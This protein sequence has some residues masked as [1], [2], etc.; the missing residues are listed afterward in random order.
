MEAKQDEMKERKL[1]VIEG[2]DQNGNDG[3][4]WK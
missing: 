1:N 3:R 2:D 4:K